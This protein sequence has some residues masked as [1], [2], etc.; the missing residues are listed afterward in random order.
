MNQ[1]S[2][3]RLLQFIDNKLFDYKTS[4]TGWNYTGLIFDYIFDNSV[5]A[6]DYLNVDDYFA[7]KAECNIKEDERLANQLANLSSEQQIKFLESVL[8]LF[9]KT[10]YYKREEDNPKH[11]IINYLQRNGYNVI[12]NENS[13]IIKDTY[14]I[15]QGS[16]CVVTKVTNGLYKKQLLKEY[17]SNDEQCKRLKYEFENM[18][19]LSD[20]VGVLNVCNYNST[21]NSY[22]MEACEK[23]L[24]D[25]LNEHIGLPIKDRLD[26]VLQIALALNEAHKRSIIHRDLHLGNILKKGEVFLLSDFGLSKDLDIIRSLKTTSTPKNAH[27]FLDPLAL[28]NLKNYDMYSDMYSVGKILEYIMTYDTS[29]INDELNYIINKSTNRVKTKRYKTMEEMCNDIENYINSL[30]IKNLEAVTYDE[31]RNGVWNS[32][33][34]KCIIDLIN[35]N[36]IA[37]EIVRLKLKNF[38][39]I[40]IQ[41]PPDDQQLLLENLEKNYAD[42]TGYMGFEN[43][44]IFSTI[45]FQLIL[46]GIKNPMK[47]ECIRI[48]EGCAKYRYKGSNQLNDLKNKGI[49]E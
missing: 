8:L 48:L 14:I 31:I 9:D 4:D 2:F 43:Y 17:Q 16:Y 40:V 22:L 47:S 20:V 32:R 46:N 19:K 36:R 10:T 45:C 44:D 3:M 26:I 33:T 35:S 15:G 18:S 12:I 30:E 34:N 49:I 23:N 27:F 28:N 6:I 41:M 5:F 11:K 25:Y 7:D 21:D 1:D 24:Y 29:I 38:A 42:A 39:Q 37:Y 13:V